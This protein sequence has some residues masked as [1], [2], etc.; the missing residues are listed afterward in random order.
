MRSV[1]DRKY[2]YTVPADTP[3]SSMTV[4]VLARWNPSRSKQ[5]SAA[6][7]TASLFAERRTV[8]GVASVEARPRWAELGAWVS[9]TPA[10]L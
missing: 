3:A 2:R 9:N 6:A 8:D 10:G 5:R 7:S 4:A 1:F